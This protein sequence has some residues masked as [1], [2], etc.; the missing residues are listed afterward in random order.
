MIDPATVNPTS[1]NAF[2][3]LL[4]LPTMAVSLALAILASA[5]VAVPVDFSV[6]SPTAGK[7]FRLSEAKG[8]FVALHFLLK[9]ECPFCLKHTRDYATKSASMPEVVQVFLKPDS[10][11]EIKAW[12]A[13]ANRGDETPDVPVYRDVD[14]RVAD[15]FGIPAGYQFHGQSVHYPAL[16]LLDPAGKEVFRYGKSNADRFSYEQFAGMLAELKDQPA[17]VQHYNLGSDK[18]AIG[19]YDPVAYFTQGKALKGRKEIT[20]SHLGVTYHFASEDNRKLFMAS[21]GKYVPTY[22]GWCATA[23]AKG[24]KVE[25]DPTNFKVTNGRLFLF[26]KAFYANA[27]KDWNKDEPN[28]TVKADANWKKIAGE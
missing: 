14:A 10:A 3:R 22:G 12:A 19:G 23:M 2:R 20:S 8:K 18:V 9:T 1:S 6:E 17:A 25:I 24:E 7:T 15:Q 16:V 21:P 26:F 11:E 5:A 13:K 4:K 27:I 28:L